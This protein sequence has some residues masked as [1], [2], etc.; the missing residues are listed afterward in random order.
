MA[1]WVSPRGTI[2]VTVTVT[3]TI[4]ITITVTDTLLCRYA[5]LMHGMMG[6][7]KEHCNTIVTP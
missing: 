5:T 6:I 4:T 1:L 3:V 7:T 2:T